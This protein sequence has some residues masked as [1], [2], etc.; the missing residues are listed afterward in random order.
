MK[1]I[2]RVLDNWI[3]KFALDDSVSW[4]EFQIKVKKIEQTR[5][6]YHDILKNSDKN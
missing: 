3:E 2:N 5:R 6:K 4:I 1:E